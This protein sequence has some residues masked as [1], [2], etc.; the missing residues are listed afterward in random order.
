MLLD[1]QGKIIS[2]ICMR[3]KSALIL[4]SVFIIIVSF[5]LFSPRSILAYHQEDVLG[6]A[7][8][9]ALSIPPT[10]E[11]PG[12]ILPNSPLFFLDRL[13]QEVRLLLAFTSEEKAKIHTLVAG[14]RLAE[15]QI[16]LSENNVSG[17]RV[18]LQGVSD[19]M[20]M[21]AD[22]VSKAKLTG[23]NIN[24]LA[25]EINDS[26]KEKKEK[27]SVLEVQATGEVKAQVQ[28]AK[29]SLK[30]SKVNIEDNL[31]AD[32]LINE[33]EDDLRIEI[34]DNI[35]K[36]AHSAVGINRS[37]DVLTRLASEAASKN[38]PRRYEA[39]MHAIQVKNLV[40]EFQ[41]ASTK[42]Q[43]QVPASPRSEPTLIPTPTKSSK[44]SD[45]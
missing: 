33:M 38:Q 20:K 15:L 40:N 6:V 39:L 10:S 13:K 22:E 37:I 30:V 12:L 24:L 23:R 25:K 7:K 41:N 17:T 45:K 11:G 43:K 42:L 16:M 2:N 19:N 4:A 36:A 14:E 26:I 34:D 35:S 31:P 28:A 44:V 21:A 5:L 18:A 29:E 1:K 32:L 27:L 3:K 9:E 8:A